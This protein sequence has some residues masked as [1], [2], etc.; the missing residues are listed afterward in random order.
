MPTKLFD[1]EGK[2]VEAFTEEEIKA[3]QQEAIDEHLKKNPDKSAEVT[4]LETAVADLTK[5]LEEGGMNEGQKER[6]KK[7]KEEAE[8]K[9]DETV[10]NLTKEISDLKE[11]FTGGIKNKVLDALSKKDP[12]LKAKLELKFNSLMKTGD[13]KNDEAGITQAMAEA[14]TIITGSKPA[15]GFLD[16]VSAAGARGDEQK[17][18]GDVPETENSKAMRS[19]LGIKDADAAKYQD[20]VK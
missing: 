2:E 14:A 20:Q 10:K 19:V 4:K 8:S 13:Y 3:K 15:P 1:S 12:D 11:T 7:A 18:K 17:N 5:K 6:L 9:L 16:N